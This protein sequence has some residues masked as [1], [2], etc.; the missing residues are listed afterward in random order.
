[1]DGQGLQFWGVGGLGSFVFTS[2]RSSFISGLAQLL[3]DAES[4][5]DISAYLILDLFAADHSLFDL[6]KYLD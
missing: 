1:M 6:L 2:F 5:H 4:T 3:L